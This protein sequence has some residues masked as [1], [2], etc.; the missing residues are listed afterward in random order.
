MPTIYWSVQ[1]C[2]P[3]CWYLVIWV[4]KYLLLTVCGRVN[5]LSFRLL[6]FLLIGYALQA[7]LYLMEHCFG[8]FGWDAGCWVW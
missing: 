8:S 3:I 5:W 2:V 6:L 7:W 4:A 1:P